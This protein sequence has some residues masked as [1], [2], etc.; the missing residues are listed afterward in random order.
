M[1]P[2]ADSLPTRRYPWVTRFLLILNLLAFVLELSLGP[3]GLRQLFYTFGVVPARVTAALAGHASPLVFLTL[4]TSQFLHAG[5]GHLIG[6][7]IFFWI[8]A[9]NVEDAMGHLRFL[10]FYLGAGA[11]G[12][13]L[14][15]FLDPGARVPLVGASGAISGVLGAYLVYFPTSQVIVAVPIFFFVEF[16]SLPA[17]LFLPIWFAEQLLSGLASLAV[18]AVGGVAWWAHVGGFLFGAGL[19]PALRERRPP[20]VPWELWW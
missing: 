5:W 19:A 13:L 4:F 18:P 6:N 14:H 3:R 11:A 12:A 8:F 17:L 2:V 20:P 15:V 1:I 10:L 7:M 9:D 16:V